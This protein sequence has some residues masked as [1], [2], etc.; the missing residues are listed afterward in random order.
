MLLLANQ[1]LSFFMAVTPLIC[2]EGLLGQA[3]NIYS[4]AVHFIVNSQDFG[5]KQLVPGWQMTRIS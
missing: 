3:I 2:A 4:I 5:L 1:S